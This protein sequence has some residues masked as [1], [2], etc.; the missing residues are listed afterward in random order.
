MLGMALLAEIDVGQILTQIFTA[1][2]IGIGS[3]L[4]TARVL[5]A[6]H[7]ERIKALEGKTG[8]LTK[9][10]RE[11][12]QSIS[13]GV[14]SLLRCQFDCQGRYVSKPEYLTLLATNTASQE[15][16]HSS[17]GEMSGR[18]YEQLESI[19]GRIT[20]LATQVAHIAGKQEAASGSP[21]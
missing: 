13:A 21:N 5:L 10:D 3:T 12:E 4:I 18:I 17:M 9:S 7:E 16:L 11:Q 15:H 6:K 1:A 8:E 14:Q 19:H 2:A 20:S